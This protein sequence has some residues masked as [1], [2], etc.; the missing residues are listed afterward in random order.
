MGEMFYILYHSEGVNPNARKDIPSYSAEIRHDPSLGVVISKLGDPTRVTTY[1]GKFS[2]TYM[3][4][5]DS[6]SNNQPHVPASPN[7]TATLP[8]RLI[9]PEV[10]LQRSRARAREAGFRARIGIGAKDKADMHVQRFFVGN[11]YELAR[12]IRSHTTCAGGSYVQT[13]SLRIA[14]S[15]ETARG[16]GCIPYRRR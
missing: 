6:Y 11:A 13:H 5:R 2:D 8:N 14:A 12:S 7:S 15:S 4:M 10:L 16:E 9:D 1:D 3:Y